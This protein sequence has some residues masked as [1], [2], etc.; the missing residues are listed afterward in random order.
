MAYRVA[1][2]GL[3]TLS[4]SMALALKAKSEEIQCLGWDADLEICKEVDKSEA[5]RSIPKKR[6]DVYRNADLII[7]NVAPEELQDTLREMKDSAPSEAVFVNVSRL[8]VLPDQWVKEIMGSDTQFVSLLPA[9]DPTAELT[10]DA[11][12][13]DLL[14]GGASLISM[15]AWT[16]PAVVDVAV[17]LTVLLGSMPIFADAYEVDGLIAANLLLPEMTSAALM[18][19]VSGQPSWRDGKMLAGCVLNQATAA[20]ERATPLAVAQSVH[21]NRDNAAR[22]LNDLIEKLQRAK[23]ALDAEDSQALEEQIAQ[24]AK[25]REEWLKQRQQPVGRKNVTSSIPTA[26]YALERL[27]KRAG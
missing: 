1:M 21:A 15:P 24:A 10:L 18:L 8:H 11:A 6:K 4:V 23:R 12:N 7:L 5:F 3:D 27:L 22:V 9:L 25:A 17:D 16:D 19:A 26:K 13:A 2:I 20:L 14:L